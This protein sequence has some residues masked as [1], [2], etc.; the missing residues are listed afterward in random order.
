M[1][2]FSAILL[3][4]VVLAP[5]ATAQQRYQDPP[6]PIARILDTPPLPL[7]TVSPDRSTLLLVERT[8]LPSIE[9]VAGPE[10]RLAGIRL[11]PRN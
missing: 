8:A 10:L 9:E 4:A 6:Q 3:S 2:R 5:S 1:S 11:D 7:V